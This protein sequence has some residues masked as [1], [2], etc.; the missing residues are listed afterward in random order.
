MPNPRVL[1]PVNVLERAKGRLADAYTARQ[2]RELA[3][4]TLRTVVEAARG[5]GCD[6]TLL[7]ADESVAGLG[8]DAA[9][10]PEVEGVRGLNPQLEAWLAAHPDLDELL[11]LHADLPLATPAALTRF[12]AAAPAAPSVTAIQS[13]DG[14][15][16]AMLIRPVAGMALHY[17]KG[18]FAL[19]RQA[20][21]NA[22]RHFHEHLDPTLSLDL[23][24][25]SDV[26]T[27]L[28]LPAGRTSP[29]GRFLSM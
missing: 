20:A 16:N 2:R 24:T 9:I 22:R 11:I 23:D 12:I 27:L 25:P 28:S 18:S 7:T 3:I 29:A 1:V 19:H 17:G 6:V 26:T 4:L 13:P 21:K 10:E 8:L 5:A 14:G 15:T